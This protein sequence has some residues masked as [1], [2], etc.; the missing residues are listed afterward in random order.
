MIVFATIV[1]YIL[2]GTL[3]GSVFA[4]VDDGI[5]VDD[6][7]G[8][9]FLNLFLWPC[10]I[11]LFAVHKLAGVWNRTIPA[12]I[13]R[14]RGEAVADL[15]DLRPPADARRD[16]LSTEQNLSQILDR[17]N[18]ERDEA[19]E[20]A[21]SFDLHKQEG[22]GKYHHVFGWTCEKC[23]KYCEVTKPS[24]LVPWPPF[25][26]ERCEEVLPDHIVGGMGA[27]YERITPSEDGRSN[28]PRQPSVAAGPH[29]GGGGLAREPSV[30]ATIQMACTSCN[31]EFVVLASGSMPVNDR[32]IQC[33]R[34]CFPKA[35]N[36]LRAGVGGS[37][38]IDK[39]DRRF[40]PPRS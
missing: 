7:G 27:R 10:V 24:Y 37:G 16:M 35:I 28:G 25:E 2:V 5:D 9:M 17:V 6:V 4:L 21:G 11:F 19:L 15:G 23:G 8:V 18:K 30:T 31:Q 26:C 13:A 32:C 38:G 1:G 34:L 22:F 40:N 29:Q 14:I 39:G 12:A 36:W 33:G 3:V 20:R